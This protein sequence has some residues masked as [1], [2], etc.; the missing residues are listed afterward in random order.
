MSV[1]TGERRLPP[2]S[3]RRKCFAAELNGPGWL[4][5]TTY[6][7]STSQCEVGPDGG[8]H[9]VAIENMSLLPYSLRIVA[10]C[11]SETLSYSEPPR[12]RKRTWSTGAV[13]DGRTNASTGL[14]LRHI[15]HSGGTGHDEKLTVTVTWSCLS[16]LGEGSVGPIGIWVDTR[17][18]P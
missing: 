1:N 13:I 12:R 11:A 3:R 7:A 5:V 16:H 9:H 10:Q 4:K 18:S 8:E 17:Q 14:K 15:L 6:V 2:P